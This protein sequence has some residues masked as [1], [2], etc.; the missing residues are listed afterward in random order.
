MSVFHAVMLRFSGR[1]ALPYLTAYAVSKYGV[2]AFSDALR[3]EMLPWGVRVSVIEAGAHKTKLLSG[4]NLAEQ[5]KSEWNDLSP[6]LKKEYGE[7]GLQKGNLYEN[8]K[9]QKRRYTARAPAPLPLS[10]F[11]SFSAPAPRHLNLV[12]FLFH[13]RFEIHEAFRHCNLATHIQ[14]GQRRRPRSY[15]T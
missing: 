2:A 11:Q 4:D 1:I 8:I 13:D 14:S 6:E 9:S 15:V 12:I 3:R 5:W 7:D 10:L